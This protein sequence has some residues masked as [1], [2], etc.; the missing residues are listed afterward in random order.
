MNEQNNK[1][2]GVASFNP[3]ECKVINSAGSLKDACRIIGVSVASMEKLVA[4]SSALSKSKAVGTPQIISE[5]SS[6]ESEINVEPE[7]VRKEDET[8]K[9]QNE[10]IAAST[11]PIIDAPVV[12]SI[13]P[14][15][16]EMNHGLSESPSAIQNGE[17][18]TSGEESLENS[19]VIM[20]T[21]QDSIQEKNVS[22]QAKAEDGINPT[23]QEN[24]VIDT[25]QV[26]NADVSFNIPSEGIKSDAFIE[27]VPHEEFPSIS[28]EVKDSVQL[29]N[30]EDQKLGLSFEEPEIKLPVDLGDQEQ[31]EVKIVDGDADLN[32]IDNAYKMIKDTM[33]QAQTRIHEIFDNLKNEM[34]QRSSNLPLLD[35]Q[36]D[37]IQKVL[38]GGEKS[39]DN[40]VQGNVMAFPKEAEIQNQV[41]GM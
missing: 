41:R 31:A 13:A 17:N 19:K 11:A 23:V 30:E 35:D 24:S 4:S 36:L 27:G 29:A 33:D 6:V 8:P 40:A 32:I 21:A 1:L 12:E 22:P 3:L 20:K 10:V 37:E 5:P 7:F 38:E 39:I 28:G 34:I 15:E 2:V 25:P 16:S 14:I 18:I 9:V 26:D